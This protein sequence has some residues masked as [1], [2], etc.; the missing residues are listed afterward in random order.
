V[1]TRWRE[2]ALVAPSKKKDLLLSGSAK[3]ETNNSVNYEGWDLFVCTIVSARCAKCAN[4]N[5]T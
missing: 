4:T 3:L 5:M 1:Q 2:P